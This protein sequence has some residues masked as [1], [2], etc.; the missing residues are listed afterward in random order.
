M[1]IDKMFNFQN[2]HLEYILPKKRDYTYSW[3]DEKFTVIKNL[4]LRRLENE[5]GKDINS[6]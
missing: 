2:I 1:S 6:R 3:V 5:E 4:Q